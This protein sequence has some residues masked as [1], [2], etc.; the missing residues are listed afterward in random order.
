SRRG[1]LAATRRDFIRASPPVHQHFIGGIDAR[2]MIPSCCSRAEESVA[3]LRP[4]EEWVT[5]FRDNV[6]RDWKIP[7]NADTRLPEK[8]RAAIASSIA[9]FQRGESSEALHY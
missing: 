4:V 5:H 1:G 9:E 6:R 2:S 7:W 8:V 3:G